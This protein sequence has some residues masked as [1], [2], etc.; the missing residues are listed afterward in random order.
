LELVEE[1]EQINKEIADEVFGSAFYYGNLTQEEWK[2]IFIRILNQAT[3]RG[4][5][6]AGGDI[7]KDQIESSHLTP[8]IKEI[9]GTG[10][11]END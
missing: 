9:F 11:A 7:N 8:L 4:W 2:R 5:V 6:S 1:L 10:C 3:I